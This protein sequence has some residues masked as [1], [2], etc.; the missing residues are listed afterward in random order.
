MFVYFGALKMELYYQ[1]WWKGGN[2]KVVGGRECWMGRVG[3][4]WVEG[5]W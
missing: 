4:K 1:K 5:W 3:M 2:D